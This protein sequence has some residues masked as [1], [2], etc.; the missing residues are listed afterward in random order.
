MSTI[1]L[2]QKKPGL[3]FAAHPGCFGVVGGLSKTR[4][5]GP[6]NDPKRGS[7]LSMLAV[8]TAGGT[9]QASTRWQSSGRRQA[10]PIC[11]RNTDDKCR[12][13]DELIACHAGDRFGPPAGLRLGDVLNVQGAPWAVVGL[14]GGFSG[15]AVLFRPHVDRHSF[16]PQQQRREARVQAALVPTLEALF[17]WCR[18]CVQLCL[19]MPPLEGCTLKQIQAEISHARSTLENLVDLRGPLVRARREAPGLS[20]FVGAVDHWIRLI[21]HQAQDLERFLRCEL[22]TPALN[23][24]VEAA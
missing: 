22:G 21:T 13:R 7:L 6:L 23:P 24:A 17:A 8:Q 19:A 15:Q 20:R 11:S 14:N 2:R 18:R 5:R 3:R 16:S 9:P 1:Q 4:P 12:W 10:C